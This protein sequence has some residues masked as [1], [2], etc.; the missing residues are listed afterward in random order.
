MYFSLRVGDG[1]STSSSIF[2]SFFGYELVF[3][4]SINVGL[5]KGTTILEGKI[6]GASGGILFERD[7]RMY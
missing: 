3:C 4:Y 7:P 6:G 5:D 1:F 2:V